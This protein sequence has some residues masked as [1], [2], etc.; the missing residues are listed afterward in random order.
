LIG[1]SD[2][3]RGDCGHEYG[4]AEYY[5]GK[6]LVSG[7]VHT[8]TKT[9]PNTCNHNEDQSRKRTVRFH[10]NNPSAQQVRRWASPR[11]EA[12]PTAM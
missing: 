12:Q 3:G 8:K 11:C 4:H 2:S 7:G 9:C 10:L 1:H 5:E 6:I